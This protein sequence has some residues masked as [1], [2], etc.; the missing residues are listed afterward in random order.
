MSKNFISAYVTR[1]VG[2]YALIRVD[3]PDKDEAMDLLSINLQ[4]KYGVNFVNNLD[5]V[6]IF[7]PDTSHPSFIENLL[8][9]NSTSE[10]GNIVFHS[11]FDLEKNFTIMKKNILLKE[12][13]PIN[14]HSGSNIF[15]INEKVL[16]EITKLKTDIFEFNTDGFN[17][18]WC[19]VT[20]SKIK[21]KL[22]KTKF[23]GM[24]KRNHALYRNSDEI[25][26]SDSK[27]EVISKM[28]EIVNLSKNPSDMY[29]IESRSRGIDNLP[30]ERYSQSISKY[31]AL[32]NI[33]F[34]KNK[35]S[36]NNYKKGWLYCVPLQ[37][38]KNIRKVD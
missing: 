3:I 37:P 8:I 27:K 2:N 12:P 36:A 31:K 13:F 5:F 6:E 19:S 10:Q 23:K 7:S 16:V 38:N 33:Y 11:Q 32:L 15:N 14:T 17:P 18:S 4:D 24:K 1:I 9:E 21:I 28:K 26:S 22:H 29:Y 25:Y 35:G 30:L 20:K 34:I